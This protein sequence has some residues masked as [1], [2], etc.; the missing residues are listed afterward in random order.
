MEASTAQK[1]RVFIAEQHNYKL[2]HGMP[3]YI[4]DSKGDRIGQTPDTMVEF[5]SNVFTADEASA[6]KAGFVIPEVR[7]QD[8][9]EIIEPARG[10]VDAL[11]QWLRSHPDFGFKIFED[12]L[13]ESEEPTAETQANAIWAAVEADDQ[14]ALNEVIALERET[15]NRPPVLAMARAATERITGESIE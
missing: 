13:P 5:E 4:R 10:D 9:D 8:T 7:A 3:S 12:S 2:F 14:E 15:H 1:T 6:F 11:I